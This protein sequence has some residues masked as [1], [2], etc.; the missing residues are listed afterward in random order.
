MSTKPLVDVHSTDA[1]EVILVS[2]ETCLQV[3][4]CV[5]KVQMLNIYIFKVSEKAIH[6]GSKRL[7]EILLHQIYTL[8]MNNVR[9]IHIQ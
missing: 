5:I 7:H 3:Y 4:T 1:R 9:R 6:K 2:S 8:K